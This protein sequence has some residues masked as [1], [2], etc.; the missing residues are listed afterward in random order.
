LITAREKKKLELT[1]LIN[2]RLK[3]ELGLDRPIKASNEECL[4]LLDVLA[5]MQNRGEIGKLKWQKSFCLISSTQQSVAEFSPDFVFY[6]YRDAQFWKA[7]TWVVVEYKGS[8]KGKSY[9]N[10]YPLKRKWFILDYPLYTYL[11]AIKSKL[12]K[13]R[14]NKVS[15]N[16]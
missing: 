2:A 9:Q 12:S 8:K 10:G 11:E 13:P 15:C 6:T 4:Y 1:N 14:I 16:E 5:P 7:Y 3:N